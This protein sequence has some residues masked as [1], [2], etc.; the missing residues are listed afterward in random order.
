MTLFGAAIATTLALSHV[1]SADYVSRI[2]CLPTAGVSE[3][4]Y[5]V[6]CESQPGADCT[7]KEGFT[8]FNPPAEGEDTTGTGGQPQPVSASPG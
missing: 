8:A 2:A 4:P 1:A 5:W 3:E 7:C 6:D